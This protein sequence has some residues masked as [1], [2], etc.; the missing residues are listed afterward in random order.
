MVRLREDRGLLQFIIAQ[1]YSGYYF[2]IIIFVTVVFLVSI[3]SD[4]YS[5]WNI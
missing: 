5:K 2:V 3:Y 4:K 1:R